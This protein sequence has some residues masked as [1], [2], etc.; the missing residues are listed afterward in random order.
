MIK[1][2]RN[3]TSVSS[4]HVCEFKLLILLT[5]IYFFNFIPLACDKA[6]ILYL[7]SLLETFWKSMC[8][9]LVRNMTIVVE[10]FQ[11]WMISSVSFRFKSLVCCIRSRLIYI[12]FVSNMNK[13]DE[14][15]NVVLVVH[16][17]INY[18]TIHCLFHLFTMAF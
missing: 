10:L 13:C 11:I 18:W 12:L 9:F 4:K 8:V 3:E 5:E 7:A 15:L 16:V 14:Y 17:V 2:G 6:W 1:N